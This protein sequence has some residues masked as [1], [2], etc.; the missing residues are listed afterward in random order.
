MSIFYKDQRLSHMS[1]G[2]A[3]LWSKFND[4]YP[5]FFTNVKYNIRVGNAVSLPKDYPEWLKVSAYALSRK[6][7]DVVANRFKKIYIIEVRVNAKPDV[8]G[9]LINYKQ[10]YEVFYKPIIPV[11]PFLISNFIDTDLLITLQTHRIPHFVV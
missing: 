1:K 4:K 7:I 8:L 6:R 5:D 10:L 2:D 3:Y 11:I 9:T